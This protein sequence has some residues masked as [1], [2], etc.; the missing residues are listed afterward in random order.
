M[1][2]PTKFRNLETIY[3]LY[4]NFT[5][6]NNTISRIPTAKKIKIRKSQRGYAKQKIREG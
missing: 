2:C 1:K 3:K 5:A 6:M 4:R